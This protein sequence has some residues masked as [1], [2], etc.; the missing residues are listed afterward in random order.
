MDFFESM[1]FWLISCLIWWYYNNYFAHRV[2]CVEN[3]HDTNFDTNTRALKLYNVAKDDN[4][5][6]FSFIFK[7]YYLRN[8]YTKATIKNDVKY[9]ASPKSYLLHIRNNHIVKKY[10]LHNYDSFDFE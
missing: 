6:I 3:E 2:I 4:L 5:I 10:Y 9:F 7:N 8:A 1:L